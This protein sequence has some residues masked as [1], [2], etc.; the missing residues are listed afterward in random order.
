MEIT[1][2][3]I[4]FGP[5][6]DKLMRP[7]E[8]SA[9]PGKLPWERLAPMLDAAIRSLLSALA[10]ILRLSP[11]QRR[12]LANAVVQAFFEALQEPPSQTVDLNQED[13]DR[14][15]IEFLIRRAVRKEFPKPFDQDL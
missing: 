6:P 12:L 10:P 9:Q 3:E 14:E 5:G 2:K 11:D 1:A 4:L 13:S 8:D 15:R 7:N